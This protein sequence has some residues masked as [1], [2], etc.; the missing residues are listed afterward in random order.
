MSFIESIDQFIINKTS[1]KVVQ[2]W[3]VYT[4]LIVL[5]LFRVLLK[6]SHPLITYFLFI[7]LVHGFILWATPKSTKMPNPF[8][9]DYEEEEAEFREA[10][11][12]DFGSGP[13]VRNMPEILFWL[14]CMKCTLI[15][16]VLTFV[17]FLDIPAYTPI[18]VVYFITMLIFTVFKLIEHSKK[19]NYNPF[20][21]KKDKKF[22][23]N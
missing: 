18:L 11:D 8:S 20:R 14:F 10:P 3:Y 6:G 16:F 2:R 17:P 7:Y 15:A 21:S 19:Y 1:N 4:V 23:S 22:Y 9:D 13:F 5:Y 12:I